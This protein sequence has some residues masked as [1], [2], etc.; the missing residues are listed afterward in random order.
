MND[1]FFL[2]LT[3][4]VPCPFVKY[5]PAFA[6]PNLS[7]AGHSRKYSVP[8]SETIWRHQIGVDLELQSDLEVGVWCIWQ[9]FNLKFL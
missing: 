8:G 3:A 6:I 2:V 4:I 7:P 1:V 5:V 9:L